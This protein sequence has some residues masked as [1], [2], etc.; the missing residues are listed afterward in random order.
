MKAQNYVITGGTGSLGNALVKRLLSVEKPKSIT[1]FS[2][3]E[4]KQYEMKQIY[5]NDR[6]R[7]VIG[8]VRDYRAVSEVVSDA[9]VIF[10]IAA[11]KHVP[12][13]EANPY[14][15]VL[16]NINGIANII[17]AIKENKASV[18]TVIGVSTDKGVQPV[19][20]YGMTKFIQEKLL[21]DAN[22][23]CPTT[24]FVGVLYGNVIGSRGSVIPLFK[25][26]IA[27]GKLITIT[28]PTMT[29]FLLTLDL[30]VD[31]LFAAF[32]SA[33]PGEIYIPSNIPAATIGD[34]ANILILNSGKSIKKNY[35]GIRPGEKMHEVLFSQNESNRVVM[36]NGW[37]V[38]CP[39]V[40]N[41]AVGYDYISSKHVLSAENLKAFFKMVGII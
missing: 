35:I 19:N 15:A 34:I 1:I 29:R 33:L 18:D 13:C 28:D 5:S 41:E 37:Y 7:F 22:K 12:S 2:R 36:R 10:H 31:T 30:A 4:T 14:E 20:V 23:R 32:N 21:I 25:K 6:L 38:L 11:L 26:Q 40:Q 27:E 3:D 8:D 17:R 24:R 9:T 39:E 16:T